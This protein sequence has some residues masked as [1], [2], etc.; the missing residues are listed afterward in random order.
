MRSAGASKG[1]RPGNDPPETAGDTGRLG[2]SRP[3]TRRCWTS[4]ESSCW[5]SL[6]RGGGPWI[7]G[8]TEAQGD[9]ALRHAWEEPELAQI[10][11]L[12]PESRWAWLAQAGP[13]GESLWGPALCQLCARPPGAEAD[14]GQAVFAQETAD[15]SHGSLSPRG[16]DIPGSF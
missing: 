3:P 4:T 1:K 6:T 16:Q 11:R 9:H 12:T 5:P 13:G 7:T 2:F 15:L 10:L 8:D 14:S